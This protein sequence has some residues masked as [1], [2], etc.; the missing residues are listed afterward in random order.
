[1]YKYHRNT[2][3]HTSACS[4]ILSCSPPS[5][6]PLPLQS[7]LPAQQLLEHDTHRE[8]VLRYLPDDEL[9]G[10]VRAA[11][12]RVKVPGG[13]DVNVAR[14]NKLVELVESRV[15]VWGGG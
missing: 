6:P 7:I 13:Q 3:T 8:A 10:A 14:W 2:H 4:L 11:W 9:V 1:M 5:P 12:E 15:S